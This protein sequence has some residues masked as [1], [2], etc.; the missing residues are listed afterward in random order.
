[1]VNDR[2]FSSLGFTSFNIIIFLPFMSKKEK[3]K[4][5]QKQKYQQQTKTLPKNPLK[6][7]PKWNPK[8]SLYEKSH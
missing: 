5:K 8:K 4:K 3:K 7:K 1:M 2:T 6:T